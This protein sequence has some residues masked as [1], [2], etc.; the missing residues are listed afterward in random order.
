M[1]KDKKRART[2]GS[3][4]DETVR[5]HAVSSDMQETR[6]HQAPAGQRPRQ[7]TM[8]D[9]DKL[10]RD[11]EDSKRLHDEARRRKQE[12]QTKPGQPA[13]SKQTPQSAR[14]QC[15]RRRRAGASDEDRICDPQ[16]PDAASRSGAGKIY[17]P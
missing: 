15:D 5:M 4:Q 3:S 6:P 16:T 8:F 9:M 11:L 10:R 12:A 7:Q 2:P 17:D 13:Q 14:A 1:D